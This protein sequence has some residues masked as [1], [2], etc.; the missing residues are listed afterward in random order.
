MKKLFFILVCFLTA[1]IMSC[2][3]G[4]ETDGGA[5]ESNF[6]CPV[7]KLCSNGRCVSEGS[8]DDGSGGEGEIP[9]N[10][11]GDG[12]STGHDGETSDSD[13]QPD[14]QDDPLEGD[15]KPG[16][17]TKCAYQGDPATENVGPCKPAVS[18]CKEDGTWG[19]CEGAVEPVAETGEELCKNN[20]DDDCDGNVDNKKGSCIIY[21]DDEDTGDS[22]TDTS[23]TGIDVGYTGDYDDAYQIPVDAEVCNDTCVPMKA[24]CLSADINENENGLCNGLDDDCDGTVD[25]GCPC[26]AGQTQPCF[27]GPKNYR[28]VGTCQDG[29]QTCR[30]S[31]R[32]TT[33]TWG[34]CVGGISPSVDKCDNADNNCNGCKD[35]KLCCAPPIDCA[36]DV[37][38]EPARPFVYKIIDGDQIYDTGHKFNDADTA[39]WEWTLTKGPCDVVLNTVNSFVKGGKTL[40]EVGDI[41]TDNGVQNTVVSGV[42]FS[43]FKVKFR[44]SGSYKLHLKVTRTN[45]EVYECEWVL[46]VVSDGL[47]IELCW[48]TTGSVD[49][50]LHLGKNGTTEEW[51]TTNGLACYFGNCKFDASSGPNWGYANTQ[52][53]DRNGN[54][55][56]MRNP[57][58]DIDNISKVGIPENI[59][60][61]NPNDED[62]F[63][64]GVKYYSGSKITHPVINVYCG[65][66]L[67]ATYGVEPQVSGFTSSPYFWK[68]VEIK[69]VGN[70][71]SDQC[72]LTSQWN[73]GTGYVVSSSVPSSYGW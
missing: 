50:D 28:N 7:G 1:F 48:D 35:D 16:E 53:Y 20:I 42:G 54:L 38:A 15:C 13:S 18:T 22:D 65:G 66:T 71:A 45:G 25:E 72:E 11:H 9:D 12:G 3:G 52:N 47:R 34:E 30:V 23:D 17:T 41:N 6:D 58:L 69:W 19:K 57:R 64:V 61:D 40:E 4:S 36:F 73:D 68:V 59:N 27:L 32:A 63:R 29:V 2:G 21:W 37:N 70:Y 24:E 5:C 46:R 31:M 14:N 49:V 51:A 60:V 55:R 33:G 43:K 44:L 56:T 10:E 8:A 26:T 67:R 62:V 39:T